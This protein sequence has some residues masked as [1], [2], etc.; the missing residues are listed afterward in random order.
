MSEHLKPCPFCGWPVPN[1]MLYTTTI[2][3]WFVEC[4]ECG[5]KGPAC[6]GAGAL[7]EAQR[8]WNERIVTTT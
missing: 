4:P 7:E 3:G 8:L 2:D 5:A 6:R 1:V